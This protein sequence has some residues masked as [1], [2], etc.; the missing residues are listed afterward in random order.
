MRRTSRMKRR[1]GDIFRELHRAMDQIEKPQ[2]TSVPFAV[3]EAGFIDRQCPGT[4]CRGHFKILEADWYEK[5]S[6]DQVYCP[7]CHHGADAD[8]WH[9]EE[10]LRHLGEAVNADMHRHVDREI[11]AAVRRSRPTRIGPIK[12]TTRYRSGAIP[13]VRPA[14][15]TALRQEFSCDEC[16][17]R[18]ASLGSSFFCPACGH[19]AVLA[20]FP[21][22]LETIRK[23]VRALPALQQTFAERHGADDAVDWGRYML[24][25]QLERLVGAFEKFSKTLFERLPAAAGIRLERGVFQRI[26]DA[27]KLWKRATGK[28][29]EDLLTPADLQ[30]LKLYFERRH[31]RVHTDG[32]VDRKYI[33]VSRDPT[34]QE[35]QRLVIRA[36]DV[37]EFVDLIEKLANGLR[38][39]VR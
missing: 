23:G 1:R 30:R 3:D 6:D 36:E 21:N 32:V 38:A 22:T 4:Q 29:Y 24:E 2:T 12:L 15:A 13:P 25:L 28:G 26:D 10:Q 8:A 34:Y 35:G 31:K 14:E 19:D 17:C 5:V 39:L 18:Y 16:D 20:N 9:T 7:F 33:N 37:L 11:G 27:S